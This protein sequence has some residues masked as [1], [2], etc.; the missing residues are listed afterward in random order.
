[1]AFLQGRGRSG[2]LEQRSVC[3]RP[4][5]IEAGRWGDRRG[6]L[7]GEGIHCVVGACR[8]RK[9]YERR[10]RE[11]ER[12]P[13]HALAFRRCKVDGRLERPKRRTRDFRRSHSRDS[14]F[15]FCLRVCGR[16]ERGKRRR[17][18]KK[19]FGAPKS[20]S[21]DVKPHGKTDALSTIERLNEVSPPPFPLSKPKEN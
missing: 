20:S 4:F 9:R 3:L 2:Q 15:F 16:L 6:G 18:F 10:E 5:A 19:L 13:S 11:R 7:K 8:R 12:D 1:M 17:M 14:V 21:S